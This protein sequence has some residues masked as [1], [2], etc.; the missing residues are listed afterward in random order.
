MGTYHNL[1]TWQAKLDLAEEFFKA[2]KGLAF[3]PPEQAK[4]YYHSLIDE[5]LPR[6]LIQLDK[7]GAFPMKEVDSMKCNIQEYAEY[8]ERC[9]I[10]RRGRFGWLPGRFPVSIWSQFVNVLNDRVIDTNRH[11]GFHCRLVT[12]FDA[13]YNLK[14]TFLLLNLNPLCHSSLV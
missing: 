11:E 2:L 14:M 9:Y 6:V 3:V 1:I 10:G 8:F 4:D 13:N 5:H 7:S 12:Y